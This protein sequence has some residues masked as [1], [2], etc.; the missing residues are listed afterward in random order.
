MGTDW[1]NWILQKNAEF[2][3]DKLGLSKNDYIKTVNQLA[4]IDWKN[5]VYGDNE[6]GK[7]WNVGQ[8]V[9][10]AQSN[11]PAQDFDLSHL[12]HL[13]QNHTGFKADE[14]INSPAFNTRSEASDLKYPIV[15]MGQAD[16]GYHIADGSH[17]A[18]KALNS[19]QKTIKA[20]VIPYGSKMPEPTHSL[21][22][23][24]WQPI[25]AKTTQP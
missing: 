14:P 5:Q 18:W 3:L 15:V 6:S 23:N 17:R 19:G 2:T 7:G 9:S 12:S 22:N 16:G 1:N 11:H 20:H 13:F 25:A 4:K 21:S 8:L 10:H 24:N